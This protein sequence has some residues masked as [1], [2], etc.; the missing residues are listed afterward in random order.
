MCYIAYMKRTLLSACIFA[1]LLP[2]C[3]RVYDGEAV[4]SPFTY[5]GT[6][7]DTPDGFYSNPILKGFYPDPSICRK[8]EDYYMVTSTFQYFPAVPVW[9]STDLVHWE[10]CGSVLDSDSQIY[11]TAKKMNLGNFAP[12]ISYNPR[13]GKFYVAC[14]QVG[15]GLGNW[16]CTTDDPRSGKWDG[17]FVLKGVRGIDPE[18]FFDEDGRAWYL[19]CTSP[20]D[21]GSPRKYPGEFA[22]VMWEFDCAS[23]QICS[24]PR[25][26]A[27]GGA[28]PEEHPENLEGP[29]LFK[30]EGQY[31]LICAEGGTEKYHREVVFGSPSLETPFVP[32]AHNPI[33]TQ[34][35]RPV[36]RANPVSCTGHADM[37][38][39]AA[40][41]WYAVFLGC[42]PYEGDEY[43]NT[44]RETFL[45]PVSWDSGQPVILEDGLDVP[46]AVQMDDELK[47]L[48]AANVIK[49]FDA[50]N[51]GPLWSADGLEPFAMT[52]RGSLDGRFSFDG[53][54]RLHL[55]CS[56]IS[57]DSLSR[58]SL[59]LQRIASQL[60]CA[61]TTMEFNPSPGQEAGIVCWYDDDHY[62]K[63]VKR[64][65]ESGR[66]VLVLEH[67]STAA[68]E[69]F[70]GYVTERFSPALLQQSTLVLDGRAASGPI[71]LRISASEPDRYEFSYSVVRGGTPV[72]FVPVGEPIDARTLSTRHC[73]G[74]QGTMLGVYA[75]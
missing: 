4:F 75:Y 67:K 39:T 59:V 43:F 14:T 69:N 8:G 47:A 44:G 63:L 40:G 50:A 24:A 31:Y 20:E 52:V 65:D 7:A 60:F 73:G 25:I 1:L 16:Y 62:A 13:D 27:R 74:H 72:G 30:V 34:K 41:N 21:A 42:R 57:L 5:T 22:I 33:L 15:G 49:A 10:Q 6:S 70:S 37:V 56:G 71:A 12:G 51:P 46:L 61:Q 45:L 3:T 68:I 17:P 9:H 29:H 28:H 64:L 32:C 54:G 55:E 2:G 35:D 38:Q 26:I 58:P 18:F 19:T 11:F 66:P 53:K 48:S 23:A 36:P